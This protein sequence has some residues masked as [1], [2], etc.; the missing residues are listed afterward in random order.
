MS[1]VCAWLFHFGFDLRCRLSQPHT[2]VV[3]SIRT[4]H[5][6]WSSAD[7]Q[8]PQVGGPGTDSRELTLQLWSYAQ[9]WGGSARRKQFPSAELGKGN[10]D[11]VY[12]KKPAS[13]WRFSTIMEPWLLSG[14]R[15]QAERITFENPT[16]WK[17]LLLDQKNKN[18]NTVGAAVLCNESGEK[19]RKKRLEK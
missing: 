4:E 8:C 5:R 1:K 19:P 7:C 17:M 3:R 14:G 16:T 10:L 12:R 6:W 13:C 15:F 18:I 2:H 9:C 11:K